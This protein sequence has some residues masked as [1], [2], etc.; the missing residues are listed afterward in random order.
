MH[1]VMLACLSKKEVENKEEKKRLK[2]LPW[3]DH[4]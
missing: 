4:R 2:A 1:A 3:E